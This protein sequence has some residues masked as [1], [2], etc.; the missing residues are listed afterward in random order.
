VER[1]RVSTAKTW[2]DFIE[3][4]IS[5]RQYQEIIQ[6]GNVYVKLL[7]LDKDRKIAYV[8]LFT[9]YFHLKQFMEALRAIN[10]AI[11]SDE[12]D[13]ALYCHRAYIYLEQNHLKNAHNDIEK[14]RTLSKTDKLYEIIQELENKL[15]L[16]YAKRSPRNR[17]I[18]IETIR[19]STIVQPKSIEQVP[20]PK[21]PLKE[22]PSCELKI[23]ESLPPV[24]SVPLKET[25]KPP[26]KPIKKI[27]SNKKKPSSEYKK[28]LRAKKHEKNKIKKAESLKNKIHEQGV[29]YAKQMMLGM[30]ENAVNLA[31]NKKAEFSKNTIVPPPIST[32]S[33]KEISHYDQ[34]RKTIMTDAEFNKICELAERL[35]L[36]KGLKIRLIGSSV[37]R[38]FL[39]ET[40]RSYS[41]INR[42]IDLQIRNIP[43]NDLS[44]V[45]SIMIEKKYYYIHGDKEKGY[46]QFSSKDP[47]QSETDTPVKNEMREFQ[48]TVV[49]DEKVYQGIPD[50]IDITNAGLILCKGTSEKF[51]WDFDE[52][53]SLLDNAF[54]KGYF[55]V[56]LSPAIVSN[57]TCLLARIIKSDL[58]YQGLLKA[59]FISADS[60]D[61]IISD[62]WDDTEWL[63]CLKKYF[64]QLREKNELLIY[65]EINEL[66]HKSY[67]NHDQAKY[68]LFVF[69]TDIFELG[70]TERSFA[71]FNMVSLLRD[72]YSK[73]KYSGKLKDVTTAM[74]TLLKKENTLSSK[75][76]ENFEAITTKL[77]LEITIPSTK[78]V[79]HPP[80]SALRS[81]SLVRQNPSP[82]PVSYAPIAPRKNG[83]S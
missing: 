22:T 68:I 44:K 42:D 82:L 4:K 12:N 81:V 64:Q 3:K 57:A 53:R 75:F 17:K 71:E 76:I 6:C 35:F 38:Y 18:I 25:K 27:I 19:S 32:D 29:T 49:T 11:L 72:F 34:L 31:E 40:K 52:T 47:M 7:D 79:K 63:D 33:S 8:H 77:W 54:S 60:L 73:Y 20:S 66:I 70:T 74:M 13:G 39:E 24:P 14:A 37:S 59:R 50:P 56:N 43:Q 65:K 83:L 1:L 45:T 15:L 67:L 41:F 55:T 62:Q 58:T 16:K 5:E 51:Y 21:K 61:F 36:I 9:A 46:T 78:P 28:N 10:L 80:Q 23:P 48:I 69:F 30:I 2:I 26:K